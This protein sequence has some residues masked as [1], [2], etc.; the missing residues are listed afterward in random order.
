MVA[1]I[2]TKHSRKLSLVVAD[3]GMS[4]EFNRIKSIW[5]I[6][7]FPTMCE[8]CL[9][10]CIPQLRQSRREIVANNP[11]T[12]S[13][14]FRHHRQNFFLRNSG[15]R[16]ACG[17]RTIT[18]IIL[19]WDCLSWLLRPKTGMGKTAHKFLTNKF[20]NILCRSPIHIQT[21]AV[22]CSCESMSILFIITYLIKCICCSVVC[23]VNMQEIRLRRPLPSLSPTMAAAAAAASGK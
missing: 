12:F 18:K 7:G 16:F 3:N 11:F 6:G 1:V 2:A 9:N 17:W 10:V 19:N 8:W 21:A 4:F 13:V 15:N 5:L 23:D 20:S 22:F 14:I